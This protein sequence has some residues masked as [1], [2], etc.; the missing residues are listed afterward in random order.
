MTRPTPQ[1]SPLKTGR[2]ERLLDVAEGLFVARGYRGTTIEHLAEAAGLSKVT[3]YNYFPDK[4]AVFLAVAERLAARLR[5][6]V[7]TELAGPGTPAEAVARALT[8]KQ[9]MVFELVRGSA[10]AGELLAQKQSLAPIF[11]ALDAGLIAAIG[12][13]LGDPALARLLFHASVGLG[14]AAATGD[15]LACDIARLVAGLMR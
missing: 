8:A 15:E 5:A 12:D 14:E 2:R 1:L 11:A 3:V 13:R 4:E 10:F 6:A 7:L 9:R